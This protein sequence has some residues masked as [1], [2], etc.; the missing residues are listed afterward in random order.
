MRLFIL[1]PLLLLDPSN[2]PAF[3]EMANAERA[4]V[5]RAQ[6]VS[7]LQ[8]FIESF[9]DEAVGFQTGTPGSAQAD[10]RMAP[11]ESPAR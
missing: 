11:D 7:V 2:P 4:F 1:L 10:M 8:A 6:E 5:Q 9:A 3:E